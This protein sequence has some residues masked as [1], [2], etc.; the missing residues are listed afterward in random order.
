LAKQIAI[1]ATS[2]EMRVA[3]MEDGQLSEIYLE[4]EEDTGSVGNIYK[5][6]V[7]KVLPG[8]QSAFVNIGLERD[9]F[10]F[11]SDVYDLAR[12]FNV[13]LD[14]EGEP[15]SSRSRAKAKEGNQAKRSRHIKG[16]GTR[17]RRRVR[18]DRAIQ[19]LLKEGQEVIVQINREPIGTKGARITSHITLPGKYL[20]MM[21][22]VSHVGISK[23]IDDQKERNRLRN[24]LREVRRASKNG[25]GVICRTAGARKSRKDLEDD[26]LSLMNRW[27]AIRRKAEKA[28]PPAL[29]HADLATALKVLRDHLTDE[30]SQ[31]VVD[32]EDL[33]QDCRDFVRRTQPKLLNRIQHYS[34]NQPL[35]DQMGVEAEIDKA[36]RARVWL[37]SG[38]YLVIGQTE[39]M[40]V[41]DVNTGKYTGKKD[42]EATILKTNLEAVTEIGRQVRLRDLSGIVVIDFI[43]MAVRSNQKQVMQALEK[44]MNRDRAKY[45]MSEF[46]LVEITRQRLKKSLE[47][48]MCR[49]CP[50]CSGQSL[51]KSN[52]TVGSEIERELQKLRGTIKDREIYI[53]V[54]PDVAEVLNERYYLLRDM[55]ED[56][57]SRITVKSDSTLH[58]ERYDITVA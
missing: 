6:K 29:L 22:T 15:T 56:L 53:R 39:A 44:E 43:D 37:K 13:D 55:E 20:V 7:Q 30:F 4:R 42:V 38:G 27:Q 5:G 12:E 47:S 45:T 35:F 18:E 32:D 28:K 34:Q 3:I 54:H 24:I 48:M 41:I 9:A 46:G 2:Y 51:I 40:V 25:A 1:N 11:V 58:P 23:K 33:Y 17:I 50:Y 49:P 14:E 19:D 26:F 52:Y 10:L 16:R 31:V 21:P 8:M 36:L 57:D